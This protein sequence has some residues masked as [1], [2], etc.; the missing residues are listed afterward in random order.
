MLFT[1]LSPRE[2]ALLQTSRSK[3]SVP[4]TLK[5]R[6][7]DVTGS[8]LKLEEKLIEEE[9]KKIEEEQGRRRKRWQR[10]LKT[11]YPGQL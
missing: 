10:L 2:V 4:S 8:R 6:P 1:F 9:R 7:A 11:S 5:R 3:A